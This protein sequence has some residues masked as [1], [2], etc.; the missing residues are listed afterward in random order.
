MIRLL[1]EMSDVD[2]DSD[3]DD[4]SEHSDIDGSPNGVLSL[5]ICMT[6]YS[7]IHQNRRQWSRK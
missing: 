4:D 5:I 3:E 7:V 6:M 2:F 1:D